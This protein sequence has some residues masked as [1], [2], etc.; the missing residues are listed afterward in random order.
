[1]PG[2]DAEAVQN[3]VN[4]YITE[5]GAETQ[6]ERDAIELSVLNY[7]RAKRCHN[8]DVAAETRVVNDVQNNFE[9]RQCLRCADLVANLAASPGATINQLV[10]FTHGIMWTLGQVEML[11]Q[12]LR[13]RPGCGFHP[14][15]RVHAIHIFGHN[16]EDL[17][18]DNVVMDWN[19]LYVSALHG[20]G[21]ISRE[22]AAELLATD[23]PEGMELD[24][25]ER[26]LGEALG[27][28][29][30]RRE[31][32]ARLQEFLAK[33][34]AGL[35]QRLE[36]VEEREAIDL[37]LAVEAAMVSVNADCMKRLR[38]RP[39]SERRQQGGVTPVAPVATDAPEVRRGAGRDHPGSRRRGGAAGGAFQHP[40]AGR[41]GGLPD[42]SRRDASRRRH[43][44]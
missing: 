19:F 1:M 21:T 11:E 28:L 42:R 26:R 3:K 40:H 30:D 37:E 5:L 7:F 25:F 41:R 14:D 16:P 13:D 6:A 2:E 8:A 18:T 29:I 17:F 15:Q 38:Y 9:D 39:E 4:I 23:R 10:Q 35:V 44:Q 43:Q 33:Y 20:P 12:H 27:N 34:K 24:H 31:A 32:R 22:A 36:E